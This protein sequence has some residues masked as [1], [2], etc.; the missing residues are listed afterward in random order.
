MGSPDAYAQFF[1]GAGPGNLTFGPDSAV[2]QVMAQSGGVREVLDYYFMTGVTSGQYTFGGTGLV[3]AGS[4]PVAQFVGSF[5]WSITPGNGSINL[6]LTNTS[7]F[8]SLTYD[9]G[10]QWQRGSLP[11]PMGNT[12]QTYNITAPCH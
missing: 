10:P 2:S 11:T 7:S 12:H 4:N 6:S 5:S 8:K 1:S 9:M 3:A